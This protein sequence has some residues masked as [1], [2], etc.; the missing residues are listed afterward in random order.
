MATEIVF[1]THS[2]SE[3][4]ELGVATGWFHGRLSEQGRA[5]A[6]ELGRRRRSDRIDAVF[7]SDLRRAVETAEIAFAQTPIPILCDWRLRECDYGQLN[8]TSAMKLHADRSRYLDD[9]FPEGESWR[10]AVARA[11]RFLNDLPLRWNH[12]RVLIIGHVATRWAL[13]HFLDGIAL[14][15]LVNADFAW[16]EGWD[17]R[18]AEIEV[19]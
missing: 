8:G 11:G 5:F 10:Q 15:D 1:E 7:T 13:D 4:N 17:Y 18:T 12:A 19:R 2:L 3:D 14:E 6:S 9:P 16:R